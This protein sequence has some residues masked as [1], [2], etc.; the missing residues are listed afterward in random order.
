[1][2]KKIALILALALCVSL[3]SG[4]GGGT[5]EQ[6]TQ[7]AQESKPAAATPAANGPTT[8]TPEPAATPTPK[9]VPT[10]EPSV[11]FTYT[12]ERGVLTIS[13]RGI[14]DEA[15]MKNAARWRM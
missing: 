9:P 2:K 5:G 8:P 10:M 11:P 6:P 3:L 15:A 7:G 12:Y 4:C 14:L 13:G 1:M